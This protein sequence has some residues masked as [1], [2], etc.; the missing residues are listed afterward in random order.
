MLKKTHTHRHES[1]HFTGNWQAHTAQEFSREHFW[2]ILACFCMLALK[3]KMH[4]RAILERCWQDYH[5]IWRSLLNSQWN[6]QWNHVES[7]SYLA[8][9]MR[10]CCKFC[11]MSLFYTHDL[12]VVCTYSSYRILVTSC[13]MC[14]ICFCC[15][16]KI[17]LFANSQWGS[18]RKEFDAEDKHGYDP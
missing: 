6:H 16:T 18:Q 12:S 13:I 10:T 4:S 11:N 14:D 8:F 15:N 5:T 9:D 2:H 7:F 17:L 3:F 1:S